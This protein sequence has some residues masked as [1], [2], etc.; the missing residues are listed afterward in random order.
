MCKTL[1]DL[2]MEF[3]IIQIESPFD[4]NNKLQYLENNPNLIKSYQK[5]S[6]YAINK[7]T[8]HDRAKIMKHKFEEICDK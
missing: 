6:K 4:L 8:W 7:N 5:K 2:G 1:I 3:A